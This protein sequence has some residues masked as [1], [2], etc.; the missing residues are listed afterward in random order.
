MLKTKQQLEEERQKAKID[1]IEKMLEVIEEAGRE[2]DNHFDTAKRSYG[3]HRKEH[4]DEAQ[5]VCDLADASADEAVDLAK[6][7]AAE[8][9][10]SGN[11][12]TKDLGKEAID[13]ALK[14]KK[15][16][17]ILKEKLERLREL[18]HS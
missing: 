15:A 3:D 14:A 4:L 10:S 18:V 13:K 16:V 5:E 1:G 7:A 9:Q 2:V 8:A 12:H 11:K 17:R 6:K